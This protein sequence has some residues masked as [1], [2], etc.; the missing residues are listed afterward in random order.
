MRL[1]DN[2]RTISLLPVV[3]FPG[4]VD[5]PGGSCGYATPPRPTSAATTLPTSPTLTILDNHSRKEISLVSAE[6]VISI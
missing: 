2:Y 4:S 1:E 3:T 5:R 6:N